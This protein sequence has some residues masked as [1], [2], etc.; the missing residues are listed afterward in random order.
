M[1]P[2]K[3]TLFAALLVLCA[4][5][6]TYLAVAQQETGTGVVPPKQDEK[7]K[8]EI[9]EAG[10]PIERVMVGGKEF[11]LEVVSNDITRF[12]GLSDRKEIA[13]D[14]GMLFVF[15]RHKVQIHEFVMRDC[16]TDIDI[17]FLDQKMRITASYNMPVEE[18]RRVDEPEPI[19]P[20]RQRDLYAERLKK[21][22]SR[23]PNQYVIEL[24]GGTIAK[25]R[26]DPEIAKQLD[27][28][29]VIKLD[30]QKLLRKAR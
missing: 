29:Q 1:D 14:G 8:P 26:E 12:K 23:F 25:L 2:R 9:S 21:Y 19:D 24:K 11:R 10:H 7:D 3:L 22:S 20:R 28:G 17:I 30:T 13:E 6:I 18:P 27:N 16:L 15:P 5:L 4:G